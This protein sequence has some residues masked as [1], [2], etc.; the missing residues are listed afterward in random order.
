MKAYPL[1][2]CEGN[3]TLYGSILEQGVTLDE[4]TISWG[5]GGAKKRHLSDLRQVRLAVSYASRFRLVGLCELTF[6]DGSILSVS[7][8]TAFG[9]HDAIR[10]G[11][12]RDFVRDL[13]AQIA[14]SDRPGI[15]FF[16]GRSRDG[17]TLAPWATW[18][19]I[20]LLGFAVWYSLAGLGSKGLWLVA[21]AV[22]VTGVIVAPILLANKSAEY[23]PRTVPDRLLP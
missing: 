4:G 19:I 2:Y 17:P 6:R 15:I 1:Q 13:H 11:I 18:T 23:D 21:I 14:P 3:V 10:A 7:G 22:A 12:Y 20:A 5:G 9:H 8:A 16:A